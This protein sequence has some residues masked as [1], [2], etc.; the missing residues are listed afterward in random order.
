M[1]KEPVRA[2]DPVCIKVTELI[3]AVNLPE[4]VDGE[5]KI[6]ARFR[7]DEPDLRGFS[8]PVY[9]LCKLRAE[10]LE[11]GLHEPAIELPM[12][13]WHI[14]DYETNEPPF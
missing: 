5:H 3:G 13:A 8:D 2:G 11:V 7:A 10:L 9:S 14:N 12:E 6:N 4:S 1:S